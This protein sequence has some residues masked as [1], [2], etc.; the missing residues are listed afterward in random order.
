V[1]DD[2]NTPDVLPSGHLHADAQT[3]AR[4]LQEQLDV[5]NDEIR[6]IAMTHCNISS[7]QSHKHTAL[8]LYTVALYVAAS[9]SCELSTS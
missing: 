9:H 1:M 2:K 4:M 5:I 8:S 6:C 3:L 7:H